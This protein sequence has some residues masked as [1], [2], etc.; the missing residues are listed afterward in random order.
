MNSLEHHVA[1]VT[2]GSE[3]IGFGIAQA[4]AREGTTVYLVARNREKLER[5]QGR[6]NAVHKGKAEI[7]EGDVTQFD[8]IR[9]II[10][11]IYATEH[12]LDIF[13]NNAGKYEP[14][15]IDSEFP[16]QML[17][18]D[19]YAPFKIA[20]YLVQKFSREKRNHLKILTVVS[21]AALQVFPAGV[22]YGTAKMA[23][24]AGLLHLDKEL[25]DRQIS[26]VELY[27]LYPGTV[28]TEAVMALVRQGKLQNPTSV[29]SVVDAALDLLQ[30]KTTTRDVRIG[31]F[32]GEGIK[33]MYLQSNPDRFSLLDT[34][35]EEIIDTDFDPQ[36]LL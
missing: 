28:G 23:L 3:G 14:V 32:P 30:G 10:D 27:R 18:L 12:R 24:A 6:I 34:V 20:H 36:S 2:G 4:L 13:V 11:T 9:H 29:E 31:Y 21:Q 22:G 8:V 7:Y 15:S 1:L 25:Q 19:F 5:A 26:N 35:T 33:R 16:E 17:Q